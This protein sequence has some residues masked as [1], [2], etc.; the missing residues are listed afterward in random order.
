MFIKQLDIQGFKSYK[1]QA[2]VEDFSPGLNTIVGRN[3]SGKSNFFKAIQFVLGEKLFSSTVHAQRAELLHEGVGDAV[4]T[5]H[6][7][8][9]FDNSGRRFPLDSDEVVLRRTIGIKKD[10]YFL[11]SKNVLK[12]DVANLLESAGFS[13]SNPYYVVQQGKVNALCLMKDE[14][15]LDLLKEVA[16]I[17]VYE[18]KKKE[19]E[20]ILNESNTNREKI[21]EVVKYI[22]TRLDELKEEK[23]ELEA[24][25]ALDRQS[26]ALQYTLFDLELKA[27]VRKSEELKQGRVE[28]LENMYVGDQEMNEVQ[29][30]KERKEAKKAQLDAGS[31]RVAQEISMIKKKNHDLVSTRTQHEIAFQAFVDKRDQIRSHAEANKSELDQVRAKIV[32]IEV[33]QSK[34]EPVLRSLE[35][36]L[37]ALQMEKRSLKANALQLESKLDRKR[38]FS[39]VEERDEYLNKE[40]AEVETIIVQKKTIMKKLQ[41][42]KD[43]QKVRLEHNQKKTEELK[44]DTQ[45]HIQKIQKAEKEL[46]PLREEQVEAVEKNKTT[47]KVCDN[48]M[49]DIS[50]EKSALDRAT[51]MFK[52]TVARQV[53]SGLDELPAIVKD[54]QLSEN[55]V[56]GTLA[57]LIRPK[58]P[59]FYTAVDVSIGNSL[60]NVVV[61]TDDTAS[62]IMKELEER[63]GGRLTFKPLNQL[64]AMRK[65]S[66]KL[67]PDNIVHDIVG[68]ETNKEAT[69]L[70]ELVDYPPAVASA[71][72]QVLG[73]VL[74]CRDTEVAARMRKE[75]SVDCVTLEGEQVHRK[76]ALTGGYFEP[77]SSKMRAAGE[78]ELVKQRIAALEEKHQQATIECKNTRNAGNVVYT[79]ISALE[80]S[81]KSSKS[82]NLLIQ[83]E[84]DNRQNTCNL[85]E[86]IEQNT[87]SLRN[88]ENS[89]Q[90]L[91]NRLEGLRVELASPMVE[92]LSPEEQRQ[93]LEYKSSLATSRDSEKQVSKDLN[94]S[95]SKIQKLKD[96][97]AI[98]HHPRLEELEKTSSGDNSLESIDYEIE[99]AERLLKQAVY[100][101]ESTK[102]QLIEMEKQ[103]ATNKAKVDLCTQEIDELKE[104]EAQLLVEQREQEETVSK[105]SS[106]LSS[107]NEKR[108]RCERQI[109]ELGSLASEELA[110]VQ[111]TSI[112]AL[113]K[114]IKSVNVKLEKYNHVNKKALDQFLSFSD[115]REKL[116]KRK[117]ELDEGQV[118]I[119]ELIRHLDTQ[120]DQDILRTFKG[121]ARNFREVFQELVPQGK[122]ELVMVTKS[123]DGDADQVE[124]CKGVSPRVSFSGTG[125]QFKMRQLSGGQRALVALTLIFAIQRCDP[126]PFY[127]FDEIDQALD[128]N[129]RASVASMIQR[130][131]KD[132]QFITT[133]FRP[134]LVHVAN[135]CF[136]IQFQNKVSAM[137]EL[138]NQ[139]ALEFVD[140]I[141]DGENTTAKPAKRNSD[142]PTGLNSN[143]RIR[144]PAAEVK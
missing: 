8:I 105:F 133:T 20:K 17:S 3:G 142:T 98:I 7:Q 79:Q 61:D 121:V 110:K 78:I 13:R 27:A 92:V 54:L 122:G 2:G 130:Q 50:S 89:I 94:K 63:K 4:M 100:E 71:L 135:K 5:A 42:T 140:N 123:D 99:E 132:A 128:A 125:E 35:E 87:I 37:V 18:A 45:L 70:I 32:A 80:Q 118:S 144:G 58:N 30:Q 44:S 68:Y 31:T 75:L 126:A 6:V 1:D 60:T 28:V 139:D 9:I 136:G 38:Q 34:E 119:L 23:S 11:N 90:E 49:Q 134:E 64:E 76:G 107:Q 53:A 85:E 109:R 56:F 91:S 97:L 14:H 124:E 117:S 114:K 48:L 82:A 101:V 74:L 108:E 106:K 43:A 112:S 65:T 25:R 39:N 47:L 67:N 81:I 104:K 131:S 66:R 57:E 24:F 19:S 22:E 10:E 33:K 129:H 15:R 62:R 40:I 137:V 88:T 26:R 84:L 111:S 36:Q 86:E 113:E 103:N 138:N 21:Q 96:D 141:A 83:K 73:K 127:L 77:K 143:K 93:L 51:R 115:Q 69:P 72:R 41:D 59:C 95:K 12:S 46:R 52:K 116:L 55:Q 16:G 29:E 102:A 120:K